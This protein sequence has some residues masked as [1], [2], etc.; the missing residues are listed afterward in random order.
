MASYYDYDDMAP[1]FDAD[2][3]LISSGFNAGGSDDSVLVRVAYR[4]HMMT[5]FIG[6]LLAGPSGERLFM[7]TI[8]L[9]SE[10]YDFG[11]AAG[12]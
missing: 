11:E 1:Q 7:S 3:N 5:P 9:Q 10:P 4:Y 12:V 6:Q 2:G 8:V